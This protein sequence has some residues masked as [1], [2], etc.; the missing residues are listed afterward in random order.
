MDL[1]VSVVVVVVAIVAAVVVK[2]GMPTCTG[3]YI[4]I[5]IGCD[6][7]VLRPGFFDGRDDPGCQGRP[8]SAPLG[9]G[10][11]GCGGHAH[12]ACGLGCYTLGCYG[13]GCF[14]L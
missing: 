13:L 7:V 1:V 10:G 8:P 14:E 6:G 4:H 9:C 12:G 2:R 3:C 5:R 11:H